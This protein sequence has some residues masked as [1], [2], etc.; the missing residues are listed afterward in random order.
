MSLKKT[1]YY[2]SLISIFLIPIFP[3]IVANTYFFPFITGKAFLFRFLVEIA[4]ASWVILAFADAKY[5]PKLTPL[6]IG[7]SVFALVAL[8]ADLL[9]V[10]PL[11]SIWSNFERMEGWL[12]IIHLWA[13]FMVATNIFG[14]DENGK[15]MWHK[16]INTSLF[17]AFIVAVYGVIQLFGWTAIHQG[18]T[19]IDA[20][21]GNA[22][23]M[24]VYLMIHTFLAS[25]LFIVNRTEINLMKAQKRLIPTSNA[26]KFWV[27]GVIT[28]LFAYLVFETQTRGTILGLIGGIMI[29]LVLYAIFAKGESNKS[30]WISVSIIL[31]MLIAGGIFWSNKDS[32]FVKNNEILN[33]MASISISDVKT[34]ARGYIWPM[35]INGA[36]ERPI[37]GWGQENFN[38]IF[39]KDYNPKM[40]AQEQWFDRAHS[41]YLDWFVAGGFVGLI[42]YLSLYVLFLFAVWKSRLTIAEK[43]VLTGLLAGYAI[44]NIFVFDNLASYVLFF[45]MLGFADSLKEGKEI[46]MLGTNSLSS[47]AVEYVILPIVAVL[48][49]ASLYFVNYRVITANT[50]LIVALS[51]CSGNVPPDVTLFENALAVNSYTANQEIR[52]QLLSCAGAVVAAPQIPGPIKQAFFQLANNQIDAQKTATPD[53]ARI[54]VLG[55]S[56][57]NNVGQV[58]LAVPFLEKAHELSPAKQSIILP[59][60]SDYINSGKKDEALILLKTAYDSAPDNTNVRNMYAMAL[61]I[62]GKE[63][64]SRKMFDNDPAIFESQQMAQIYG[65]L[66]QYPK[67]IVLYKKLIEANPTDVDLRAQLAQ[68]QFMSGQISAS[69]ATLKAIEKDHP[70]LK[71]QIDAAIKQVQK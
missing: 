31:V 35:A 50:R 4:F 46:K 10:N 33:R 16:W 15:R 30:R 28:I 52:E 5:R 14:S 45:A 8:I 13:F 70:E 39:N 24:A 68:M 43:S 25:Y 36:L 51:G 55:G 41:V 6:M 67:A 44:H 66:K 47:D 61:V 60:A 71:E 49:V 26:V 42:S 48:L 34:Q 19:R 69:V 23:Y 20:S 53:D 12:V 11:R 32:Q 27:Y 29:A 18:S 62:A 7:V 2:I 17:I 59:L 1:S 63:T 64:E 38:Y 40:W 54:Y 21:L 3:L 57:M 58:A 65:S 22:A 37:F 56:F 9:G